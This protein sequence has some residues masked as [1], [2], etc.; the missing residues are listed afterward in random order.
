MPILHS[1]LQVREQ[2]DQRQRNHDAR[3]QAR[4]LS[5]EERWAKKKRKF[6]EDAAKYV[7][8]Y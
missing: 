1:V 6:L 2:M 3:N 8:F 4:K 7:L 5:K